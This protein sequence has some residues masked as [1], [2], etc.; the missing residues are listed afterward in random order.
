MHD[1]CRI[2]LY[3]TQARQVLRKKLF[4]ANTKLFY[5]FNAIVDKTLIQ[6]LQISKEMRTLTRYC[7]RSC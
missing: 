7:T 2:L 5:N 3:L 6:D 4:S 1:F